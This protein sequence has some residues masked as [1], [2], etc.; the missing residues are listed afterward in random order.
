MPPCLQITM[1]RGIVLLAVENK[2]Y[3][4]WAYNMALSVKYHSPDL[5]IQVVNSKDIFK[6]MDTN[7]FD[8][9]SEMPIGEYYED[10]FSPQLAKLNLYKY[11]V[12]DES[13]YLDVDGLVLKPIE[14]LF[15]TFKNDYYSQ[16][17][18]WITKEKSTDNKRLWA[19]HDVICSHYGLSAEL[20]IPQIETGIQF[21]R[22]GDTVN[23]IFQLALRLYKNKIPIDKLRISW[24][25]SQPDEL[26][27]GIALSI[28]GINPEMGTPSL[29]STYTDKIGNEHEFVKPYYVFGL[30]G[31]KRLQHHRLIILYDSLIKKYSR[32][33]KKEKYYDV[34]ILMNNKFVTI[35]R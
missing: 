21:F 4:Q 27:I 11:L 25:K 7:V 17:S 22:K 6:G 14:P 19:K 23:E 31:N 34:N 10:K 24:G 32:E 15:E 35:D 16:A 13:I 1:K 5:P 33:L 29:H 30:W 20:K 18:G 3:A 12:F 26:Y 28:L 2:S 8:E 9:M